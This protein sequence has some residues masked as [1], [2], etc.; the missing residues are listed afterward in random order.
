MGKEIFEIAALL[1]GVAMMA[2]LIGHP[3]ATVQVA[4]GVANAFNGLLQ[5]VELAGGSGFAGFSGAGQ[6]YNFGG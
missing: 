1:I 4:G 3:A 5:T 6:T 2:L